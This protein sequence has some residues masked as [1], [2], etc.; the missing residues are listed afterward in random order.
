S[1]A[2]YFAQNDP[3]WGNDEYA[4]AKDPQF[5]PDWC[6]VTIAQCG[7]AM[8]SVTTVMALYDILKMP[9]GSDLTPE[10]VNAWF[11]GNATKTARG[12]VSQ[13]YIYGDVIWTAANQLSGE[14]HKIDPSSPTIRFLRAG[15]GSDEEI[16]S[17]LKAGR[18]V[19]L[20]VPGHWISAVGLDGDKILINDPYYR[21]RKTLDAYAG[22]VKSSILFEKSDDLSAVV[23]TVP[24][25]ERVRVTDKAGNVVGTLDTGSAADAAAN[26]KNQIP[27]ASYSARTGWRDPTCIASPPPAGSGTNQI[28]LPGS[29]DDYKIEVLETAGGPTSVAIHTYDKTGTPSV[30]TIDNSN[31]DSVVAQ[32]NYD[33]A[34]TEPQ[35]TV[36]AEKPV[37]DSSSDRAAGAKS[38]TSTTT[39]TAEATPT[40]APTA[41]PVPSGP[42]T[43]IM[44]T[45]SA[46]GTK[47][48]NIAS[49]QGF[50]V[51][52]II[53]FSPGAS[54][55]EDNT[56][57]GFGSFILTAP[58]KFAHSAGEI[59][60]RVA[61]VPGGGGAPP[62]VSNPQLEPPGAVALACTP[63]YSSA[64][65]SATLICT[66]TVTGTYT[67]TRWSI[68]GRV[69][70]AFTGQTVLLSVFSQ[71][72]TVA[73]AATACNITMCAS[74]AATVAIR[75]P[76][77]PEAQTTA[78]PEPT[79]PVTPT[80]PPIAIGVAANC[81]VNFTSDIDLSKALANLSCDPKSLPKDFSSITWTAPGFI[82]DNNLTRTTAPFTASAPQ[83]KLAPGSDGNAI[84]PIGAT[85]CSV[86]SGGSPT[87]T[88]APPTNVVI[89]YAT[90]T[91]SILPSEA[92]LDTNVS[93]FAV[94]KAPAGV[95]PNGGVVRFEDVTDPDN[96]KA[97]GLD[98][99]IQQ[100]G[101]IAF[102]Q[103]NFHAG[104]AP[105]D[106][107]TNLAAT[108][109]V[110]PRQ[111]RAVYGGASNIFGSQSDDVGLTL[112][113][114]VPDICNSIDDNGDGRFDETCALP[115]GA[116]PQKDVGSGTFL[117]GI[118]LSGAGSVPLNGSDATTNGLQVAP[119]ADFTLSLS[120]QLKTAPADSDPY[121][122]NC[123][124]QVYIGIGEN[125]A[126]VPRVNETG[127]VCV[128]DR[129]LSDNTTSALAL[130]DVQLKAPT[131]PGMY[132]VRATSSVQQSCGQPDVGGPEAS[133]ARIIVK[134]D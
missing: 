108:P 88:V 6:G 23:I 72:T 80:A 34:K 56:I 35:V 33:P 59:I 98:V 25:S 110:P 118:G 16:R 96:P 12:W 70:S 68:D 1:G 129:S 89:P 48:V 73:I 9:D 114:P 94:V 50:A 37:S 85:V 17:E 39:T 101:G 2:P 82:P 20:E 29:R 104:S 8:T 126:S 127:P 3:R 124:R 58:L 90:T 102:A 109:P 45:S 28:V 100:I 5:G 22:K 71:D 97:I 78:T 113:P 123:K 91:L 75:F 84:V 117:T 40:V 27:G 92:R 38:P 87:C 10:T 120:A 61:G 54:N 67:T 132:Y 52:D 133:I 77:A 60:V 36:L 46:P 47:V 4:M 41:T 111:I 24:A 43:T 55:E 95:I 103:L 112:D 64:P 125:S 116:A 13:G 74:D 122:A 119:G 65:R 134:G 11:D 131:T 26:A 15:T 81:S 62:P 69:Q 30:K 7:C 66:I 86:N 19:V 106:V 99:K 83:T 128:M 44:S 31:G 76:T 49:S 42:I 79:N 130:P 14:I 115:S 93:L 18:P 63:I 51:G 53:R 105:L 32:V 57:V 107:V 21:D 121:C